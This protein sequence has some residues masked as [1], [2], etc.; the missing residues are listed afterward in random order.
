MSDGECDEG[1][2]WES[3]LIARHFGLGNFRVIID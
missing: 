1:T 2:T 3:A